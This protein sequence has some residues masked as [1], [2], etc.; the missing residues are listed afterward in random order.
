MNSR[1]SLVLAFVL[2]VL[3]ACSST[4]ASIS[5]SEPDVAVIEADAE[6]V[7]LADVPAAETASPTDNGQTEVG[8][9]DAAFADTT[10]AGSTEDA[11]PDVPTD[12]FVADATAEDVQDVPAFT[13]LNVVMNLYWEGEAVVNSTPRV[14]IRAAPGETGIVCGQIGFSGPTDAS[15][16]IARVRLGGRADVSGALRAED[17]S[18]LVTRCGLFEGTLQVGRWGTVA[19]DGTMLIE[20]MA[21]P[22]PMAEVRVLTIRCDASSTPVPG[23]P[24]AFAIG[25]SFLRDALVAFDESGSPRFPVFGRSL[26][27]QLETTLPTLVVSLNP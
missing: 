24:N 23:T 18:R 14:L 11:V 4:V 8:T 2:A 20:E 22:I 27:N 10:D 1:F 12:T 6:P 13:Q 17:F 21:Y 9:P 15:T 16:R 5:A 3:A 19:A 26:V 7:Q 25:V